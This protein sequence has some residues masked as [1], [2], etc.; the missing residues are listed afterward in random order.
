MVWRSGQSQGGKRGL[1]GEWGLT[2]R[3]PRTEDSRRVSNKSILMP[4]PIYDDPIYDLT[5]SMTPSMTDPIYDPIYVLI[6]NL[7]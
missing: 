1:G 4:D 6:F 7:V 5:P 3:A 2:L